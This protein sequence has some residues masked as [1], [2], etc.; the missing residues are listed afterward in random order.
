M[1]RSK[2]F[3]NACLVDDDLSALQAFEQLGT[4]S[5]IIPVPLLSRS[6]V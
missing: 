6:F 3:G 2:P 5:I 1:Q 4:I